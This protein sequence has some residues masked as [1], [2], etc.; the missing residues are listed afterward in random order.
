[1]YRCDRWHGDTAV[2]EQV[3]FRRA[4]QIRSDPALDNPGRGAEPGHFHRLGLFID[5]IDDAIFP[6][7]HPKAGETPIDEMRELFRIMRTGSLAETFG[8]GMPQIFGCREDG[9]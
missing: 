7:C 2:L 8:I 6:L 5:R 1:M 3:S 4:P 9:L